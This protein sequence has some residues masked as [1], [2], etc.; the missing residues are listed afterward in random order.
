MSLFTLHIKHYTEWLLG[1]SIHRLF[2]NHII[3]LFLRFLSDGSHTFW[4][5]QLFNTQIYMWGARQRLYC[6]SNTCLFSLFLFFSLPFLQQTA[7]SSLSAA[8][9]TRTP[10]PIPASPRTRWGWTRTSPR[11]LL[12]TR[13]R[14]PVSHTVSHFMFHEEKKTLR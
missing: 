11:C 1:R 12:K 9:G 3:A 5:Q 4:V 2:W 10:A 13:P 7:V 14:R 8:S 6:C